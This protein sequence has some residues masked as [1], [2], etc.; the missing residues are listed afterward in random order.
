MLLNYQ[1]KQAINSPLNRSADCIFLLH[2]LFGSLSNLMQLA[3]TLQEN[4]DIILVDLRNHGRSPNNKEV[5]YKEMSNDI[6]ELA[7]YLSINR[8]SIAGHSMG[9]KVAMACALENPKRINNIVVADIAPV[10][11][12]DRHRA[13]FKGLMSIELAK[14]NSRQDADWQLSKYILEPGVRQFLLKSLQKNGVLFEFLFNLNYLNK[15]YDKIRDWPYSQKSYHK[16]TLFIKGADSD[17]IKKEYQQIT[18]QQFPSAKVKVIL[19]SG[20]WLHAQKPQIFNRLVSTFFND[21]R[22]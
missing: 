15:S 22:V 8:F 21:F 6:F 5:S 18:H 13:V 2:G 4:F 14:L 19:N 1:I 9:G 12:P 17:Y 3:N 11:Y 16:P 20:H 7:D 10:P